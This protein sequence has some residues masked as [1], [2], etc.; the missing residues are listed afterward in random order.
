MML[1][2]GMEMRTGF[3]LPKY[4]S[5]SYDYKLLTGDS[6]SLRWSLSANSDFNDYYF[7]QEVD[8]ITIEKFFDTTTSGILLT[9]KKVD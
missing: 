3:L 7:K 9:F 5:G 4:G 1:S 8:Q 6:I 2:R